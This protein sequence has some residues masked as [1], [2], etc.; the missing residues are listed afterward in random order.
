[1]HTSGKLRIDPGTL[2]AG[3]AGAEI[4]IVV[5]YTERTLTAAVLQRATVLTA[6]LTAAIRLVA[7]HAIPYPQ[8]FHCPAALHAH[9][10]EQLV[11]LASRCPL[12][13][14]P[15]VVLARY[16]DDGFRHVL[17]PA[18]IVLV[19]SRKRFWPTREEKLARALAADGHQVALLHIEEEKET[20]NA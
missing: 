2:E 17:K 18:S 12:A 1:M 11:D 15:Q 7:V 20:R 5:P 9:L 13:V 14:E 19:G 10:V 8:P 6:G 3:G 4:E 16:R